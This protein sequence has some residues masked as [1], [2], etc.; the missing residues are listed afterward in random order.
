MRIEIR[1]Q[2]GFAGLRPPPQVIETA[3]LD[4]KS[5]R[6]LEELAANLPAG[7]PPGRGADLMRYDV[8]V[9]DVTGSRTATFF[10]PDVPAPVRRL[11]RLARDAGRHA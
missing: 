1:Q 3:D 2:G 8:L 9:D 4:A 7:G 6:E 11:L 5:G 10:E